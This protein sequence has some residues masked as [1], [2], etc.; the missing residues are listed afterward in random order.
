MIVRLLRLLF[1]PAA[2]ALV[3]PMALVTM[4]AGY[5][6]TGNPGAWMV[7]ERSLFYPHSPR[8]GVCPRWLARLMGWK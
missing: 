7:V 2:F 4:A 8:M 5:V 6:V 3:V 1:A